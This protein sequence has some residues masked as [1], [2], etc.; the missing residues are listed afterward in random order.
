MSNQNQNFQDW[1]TV[2]FRKKATKSKAVKK[3]PVNTGTGDTVVIKKVSG[4]T[5]TKPKVESSHL[6]KIADTEI[7][8]LPKITHGMKLAMS[9]GRSAKNL[10]Q[11]ELAQRLNVKQTVIQ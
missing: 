7:A 11:K 4:G 10:T 2:V 6:R 9:Q 8:P 5:N 3:G 1:T